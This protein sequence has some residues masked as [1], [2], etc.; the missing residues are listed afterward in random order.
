MK[1]HFTADLPTDGALIVPVFEGALSTSS[2]TDLDARTGGAVKRGMAA[3]SFT[4]KSGQSLTIPGPAEM[5]DAV[6]LLLG[7]GKAKTMGAEDH[8]ALGG[9]AFAAVNGRYETAA[10][11]LTGLGEAGLETAAAAA[12][13][14]L[15]GRLRSYDFDIYRRKTKDTDKKVVEA[16]SVVTASSGDA[17]SLFAVEDAVAGGVRV[18]RDLV[19]EPPNI[20][21]PE[22]FA[23]RCKDL[24]KLGVE[25]TILD[26][27]KMTELG[28]GSLLGVGQGSVRGSRLV[29]MLWKGGP[30]DQKPVAFIGKGV[31]F[32]TGGISIKPSAGME[33]MKFDMGGAGAVT[34]AMHAIAARKAKA[35]VVGLIGLVENM[36]DGNA[37]RPSVVVTSMSGLTVVV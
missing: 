1:V 24:E 8:R 9:K 18:A 5:P 36:P 22:S 33:D 32:D 27:A 4:G 12:H 28:M 26:E 31:T 30:A 13:V 21:H 6:I 16:F 19:T 7:Q 34:G 14:A 2:L 25:V 37:Q 3:A 11:T 15:G 10:L 23:E 29:S 17:Q 35:N 20:L